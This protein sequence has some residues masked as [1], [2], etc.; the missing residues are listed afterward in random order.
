M[1]QLVAPINAM[2]SANLGLINLLPIPLLD[3]GHL[4]Y[5]SLEAISGRPLA[6]QFQEYGFRFGFMII[7]SLMAFTLYN[8]IRQIFL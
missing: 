8:D 2:L 7:A 3:G 1:K 4:M 6:R 5:Y